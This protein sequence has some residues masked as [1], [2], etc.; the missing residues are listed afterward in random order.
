MQL[1]VL[2][3][4]EYKISFKKKE[5]FWLDCIEK[6]LQIQSGSGFFVSSYSNGFL[7]TWNLILVFKIATLLIFQLYPVN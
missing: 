7:K 1:V 4:K 2:D 3:M 6:Q 5:V